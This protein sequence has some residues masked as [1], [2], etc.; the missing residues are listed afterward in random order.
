MF[1]YYLYNFY[2]YIS[3]QTN[4]ISPLKT[5]KMLASE[6]KI[7][8]T[9]KRQGNKLTVQKIE[10]DTYKNGTPFLC[11]HCSTN[12]GKVINSFFYFKLTTKIK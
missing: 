12:D 4:D 1:E 2:I 3:K 6:L 8:D 10:Q 9:F 7:G 5:N 11:V